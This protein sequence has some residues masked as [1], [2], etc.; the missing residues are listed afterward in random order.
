M[1]NHC[2]L[3]IYYLLNYYDKT[4]E[5]YTYIVKYSLVRQEIQMCSYTFK[6]YRFVLQF[7]SNWLLNL[8]PHIFFFSHS[9]WTDSFSKQKA[10]TFRENQASYVFQP[11]CQEHIKETDFQKKRPEKRSLR[12]SQALWKP[13]DTLRR[14]PP[15][16]FLASAAATDSSEAAFFL[17]PW[18]VKSL[19]SVQTETHFSPLSFK[20]VF[21]YLMGVF[22]NTHRPSFHKM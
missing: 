11:Q 20:G 13:S 22:P 15:F 1:W 19:V 5:R 16:H 9:V 10:I 4:I 17:S 21:P 14:A 12:E 2:S 8:S 7:N 6:W 3:R 18:R